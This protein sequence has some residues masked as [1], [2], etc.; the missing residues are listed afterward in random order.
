MIQQPYHAIEEI[1]RTLE[2]SLGSQLIALY[3]FGSI[4]KEKYEPDQSDI[5]LL[6]V[7]EEGTS[8]HEIR[9]ALR[10]IWLKAGEIIRQTP[11]IATPDALS[12]H[13]QVNPVL[14]NHLI[15]HSRLLYGQSLELAV[16][17]VSTAERISL[18]SRVALNASTVIGH[19]LLTKDEVESSLLTLFR[20][21]KFLDLDENAQTNTPVET[22]AAVQGFAARLITDN[23]TLQWSA[24][25]PDG[26]PPLVDSLLAIY[27][28]DERA[29]FLLPDWPADQIEAYI[30]T[31]DW[32]AVSESLAGQYKGLQLSTPTQ[33][34]LIMEYN[35][36]SDRYFH[37]YEHAWGQDPLESLTISH[38]Q[39]YKELA[40]RASR[41]EIR[42]FPHVYITADGSDGFYKV[43]HDFQNKLLN[44]QLREELM[45]RIDKRPRAMPPTPL[46]DRTA[47]PNE[48]IDAILEHFHWWADHYAAAMLQELI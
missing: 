21:A 7:V 25:P 31:V 9:S 44:I 20:L 27:E 32:T 3:L 43:I 16:S 41:M 28:M 1:N 33:F 19:Q 42:T 30:R 47:P 4:A 24:P 22:F 10:P 37:N 8:I 45:V 18:L 26:S 11:L 23:P 12:R 38:R 5:N 48:R 14:G 13:L 39:L 2:K 40:R 15:E 34:R 35:Q 36:A 17:P 46:P 6:A 29:I